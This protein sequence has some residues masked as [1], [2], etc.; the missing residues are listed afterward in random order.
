MAVRIVH[1]GRNNLNR[2]AALKSKGYSVDECHSLGQLH[3]YLVGMLPTDAVAIAES[4][5]TVED[6]AISLIRAISTAP[7]ILFRN[8]NDHYNRAEFDL[9]VPHDAGAGEWLSNIAEL[10]ARSAQRPND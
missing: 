1:F 5:G 2:I 6:H 7:L 8:G 10:I 9:V 4:D 3:A